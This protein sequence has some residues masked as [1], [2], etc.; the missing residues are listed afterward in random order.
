MSVSI[1]A[2]AQLIVLSVRTAANRTS[3]SAVEGVTRFFE[4]RVVAGLQ[5][6]DA[7]QDARFEL[8]VQE[9]NRINEAAAN[10][11]AALNNAIKRIEP[12]RAAD[13]AKLRRVAKV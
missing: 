11:E 9:A 6:L 8:F 3:N 2:Q 7:K 12:D 5:A 13:L 1:K 10:K 4:N